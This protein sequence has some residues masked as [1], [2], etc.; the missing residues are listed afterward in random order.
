MKI[1]TTIV[2]AVVAAV[3]SASH[4]Q[5]QNCN[6][7]QCGSTYRHELFV[8]RQYQQF[9]QRNSNYGSRFLNPD[10]SIDAGPTFGPAPGTIDGVRVRQ[11]QTVLSGGNAHARWCRDR[12]RSYR[13]SDDTFQPFDGPRRA[14]N[15]PYD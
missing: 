12:Y 4:A 11:R 6:I 1:P 3:T 13:S 5:A 8:E 15:S 14:C 2:L 7:G 9:L 10:I